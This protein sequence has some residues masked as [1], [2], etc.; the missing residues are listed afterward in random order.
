MYAC[1]IYVAIGEYVHF[2]E[3]SKYSLSVSY[4]ALEGGIWPTLRVRMALLLNKNCT[5]PRP[6]TQL[7]TIPPSISPSNAHRMSHWSTQPNHPHRLHP[8][9][10][11]GYL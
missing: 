1:F 4:S 2:S 9:G 10:P 7:L 11:S 3:V 5:Q 6:P 8:T